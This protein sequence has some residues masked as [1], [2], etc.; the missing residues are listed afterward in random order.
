MVS[1]GSDP[2]QIR[3]VTLG[4]KNTIV[5][6]QGKAALSRNSGVNA[7]ITPTGGGVRGLATMMKDKSEGHIEKNDS[8]ILNEQKRKLVCKIVAYNLIEPI[9]LILA[10]IDS[11]CYPN[12]AT[13]IY[14]VCVIFLTLMM[15]TKDTTK[16]KLK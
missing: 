6:S 7:L 5:G 11:V 2:E 1:G 10:L 15:L 4:S 16:I 8:N 12:L 13:A 3:G 9:L 14:F